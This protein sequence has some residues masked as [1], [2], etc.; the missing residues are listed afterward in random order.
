MK[1]N[2]MFQAAFKCQE[3][4]ACPCF[5]PQG[6]RHIRDPPLKWQ[7]HINSQKLF[8]PTPVRASI[9]TQAIQVSFRHRLRSQIRKPSIWKC[10][11][12]S[13]ALQLTCAP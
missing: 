4:N 5:T 11:L 12:L 1:S 6:A 9:E 3:K 8:Y 10:C 13:E 7:L 2:A